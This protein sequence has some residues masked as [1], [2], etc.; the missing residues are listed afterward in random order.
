MK[1]A[2][3]IFPLW[4][5]CAFDD[6]FSYGSTLQTA[7]ATGHARIVAL[8]FLIAGFYSGVPLSG[9][10]PVV[11]RDRLQLPLFRA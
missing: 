6:V 2:Q 4:N 9:N 1:M 5:P 7:P 11:H 8:G 10:T 3:I